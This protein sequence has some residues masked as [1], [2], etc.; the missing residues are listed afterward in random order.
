[1]P[2]RVGQY[3]ILGLLG[4][5]GFGVVYEAEQTSPMVRRVALKLIKPGMDSRQVVA[6]FEAER[7]ALAV[8][9]HACIARVYD[10]GVTG[11]EQGSR[12]YFVMELVRGEPITTHCDKHQLTIDE[13]VRLFIRVCEAVQHAHAKGVLH[14][15][16]KP[17]NILV[18]YDA[19]GHAIPKVI[20]FGIAKALNQ[21]LSEKTIFTELGQ[22]I[23]TPEYMSPEQAEMSG[24]DIDTRTD[25]Y[26]LGVVLYVLL[27]GMLPFDSRAL[28]SAAY[29]EIQRMI[30]ETEPPKPSTRLSTMP[31]SEES[32]QELRNIVRARRTDARA[33]TGILR[34]DLDWVVMRCLAKERERRYPSASGLAQDLARYLANEP[35]E[36]GPPSATYRVGKFVRRHRIGV[37]AAG[38]GISALG[39]GFVV[40]AV[41]LRSVQAERDRGERLIAFLES[42][43]LS[44]PLLEESGRNA[45]LWDVL[46]SA[47]DE[48]G[49]SFADDPA[50]H[51]RVLGAIG[52]SRLRLGD[53]LGA[54]ETLGRAA[55]IAQHEGIAHSRWSVRA[56]IQQADALGRVGRFDEAI[57]ALD[58]ISDVR[59]P[60]V[61]AEA[62]T[63]RASVL[64]W[65]G[66]L[67]GAESEYAR[68][69]GLWRKH[70]GLDDL[71]TLQARYDLALV[72]LERG[73]AAAAQNDTEQ[74]A[75]QYRLTLGAMLLVLGD[76]S[77]S[78]GAD[79]PETLVTKLE[80]AS[81][82]SRLREF[83]AGTAMLS[84]AIA[85]LTRR[86]GESHWRT[87]QARANL[88]SLRYRQGNYAAAIE[89]YTPVLEA[90][91]ATG[92]LATN[93]AYVVAKARAYAYSELGDPSAG[94]AGLIG[95][96]EAA[97]VVSGGADPRVAAGEI[98]KLYEQSDD[99]D[100]AS[101]WRAIGTP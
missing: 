97:S 25:I 76:Q 70:A 29:N 89:I 39:I 40:L 59:D 15:D 72:S 65:S 90:Y 63:V 16:L 41:L 61:Q 49:T 95:V 19:E 26:S 10:G 36:A 51:A 101:H 48:A 30:R 75:A 99:L 62:A 54:V 55:E 7:Q 68:A 4:E 46:S 3:R 98:A 24:Q 91:R 96:H 28:R 31:A 13:R 74:A 37:S 86:L 22:M 27:T 11:P 1:M 93:D 84:E 87:L 44:P 8:M 56:R 33:M 43:A 81:L 6:R 47:T 80:A 23:G 52:G 67:D 45:T 38:I 17:N 58:G 18:T 94:I 14:R 66:Q 92:R 2:E 35:V 42:E 34:R 57:A 64:K 53:E 9:D 5:G 78:L 77:R 100:K 32:A 21:R 71:G 12:P 60:R 82:Y 83:D 85:G 20:D 79:H 73:K 69:I 50:V 88:G